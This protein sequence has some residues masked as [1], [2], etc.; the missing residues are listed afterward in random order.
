MPQSS[1]ASL[2]G[3]RSEVSPENILRSTSS[4]EPT[5]ISSDCAS[6]A[7][8]DRSITILQ[9]RGDKNRSR[10][11]NS[12]APCGADGAI[13]VAPSDSDTFCR[14]RA[15]LTSPGQVVP[16]VSEFALPSNG[17]LRMQGAKLSSPGQIFPLPTNAEAP[18]S[19]LVDSPGIA[20]YPSASMYA[21]ESR[22]GRAQS[23]LVSALA[24]K[25]ATAA[26]LHDSRTGI[27]DIDR[28]VSPSD[29]LLREWSDDEGDSSASQ[30]TDDENMYE[31]HTSESDSEA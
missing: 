23:T 31:E 14:R 13:N 20:I 29:A 16:V 2:S 27:G 21:P 26:L 22:V 19:P 17:T 25:N 9:A 5:N 11:C 7:R 3:H 30:C 6:R 18:L 10:G 8:R 4:I 24:A 1:V 12:I 28:Y 15:D